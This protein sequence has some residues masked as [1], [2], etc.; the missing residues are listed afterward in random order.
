MPLKQ[1]RK[2]ISKGHLEISIVQLVQPGIEEIFSNVFDI[3]N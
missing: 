2:M 3:T 1:K